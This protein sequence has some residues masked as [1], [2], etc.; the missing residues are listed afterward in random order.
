MK[1]IDL[2]LDQQRLQ[3]VPVEEVE[4]AGLLKAKKMSTMIEQEQDQKQQ[5][6][7]L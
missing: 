3:L 5:M 1:I 4:V 6:N 7:L 2:L